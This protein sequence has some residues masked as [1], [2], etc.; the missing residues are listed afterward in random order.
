MTS[1]QHH[2]IVVALDLSEYSEVVLEHALDQAARHDAPDLH[3]VTVADRRA[4]VDEVKR[5]LAALVLEGLDG[6]N[7]GNWRA[8]MHVRIGKPAEEIANLAAE[9]RAH[10][11]V[12][13]RFGLHH[14][15]ARLGSVANRV[16]EAAS[17]PTLVVGLVDQS[18]DAQAACP[19]CVEVRAESDGE[20]WFCATHSA[21]D[22]ERFVTSFVHGSTWTGGGLMW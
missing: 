19:D 21:P 17:C 7:C 22:H 5:R 10:L 16:I 18:P 1:S 2:R 6:C 3:F 4:D 15:N 11:V 14:S 13:G 9:I 12:V 20:R 8:R